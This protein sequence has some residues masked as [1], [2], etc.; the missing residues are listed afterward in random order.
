MAEPKC[1][2]P[3]VSCV[4]IDSIT[5]GRRL[6]YQI[7]NPRRKFH[8]LVPSSCPCPFSTTDMSLPPSKRG[9]RDADVACIRTPR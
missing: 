9:T 5:Q 7:I 1:L 4:L 2:Q 3:C 8:H 6:A